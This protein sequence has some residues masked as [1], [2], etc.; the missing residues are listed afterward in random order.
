MCPF[1]K[2]VSS[3]ECTILLLAT[4]SN[5]IESK[6][7]LWHTM[8]IQIFCQWLHTYE[9]IISN[10]L[11]RLLIYHII[12][13]IQNINSLSLMSHSFYLNV[14]LR[15]PTYGKVILN[16]CKRSFNNKCILANQYLYKVLLIFSNGKN[17]NQ[18]SNK[19]SVQMKAF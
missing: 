8:L 6:W 19:N 12:N 3:W 13:L 11:E 5:K 16:C 1:N 7:L 2:V 15:K 4:I 14:V 10:Q 18:I 17:K 9:I